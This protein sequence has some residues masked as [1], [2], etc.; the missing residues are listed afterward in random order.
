MTHP[1]N[2]H[3]AALI[4]LGQAVYGP[5]WRLPPAMSGT[6]PAPARR[7]LKPEGARIYAALRAIVDENWPNRDTTSATA[8]FDA[9]GKLQEDCVIEM[10][11]RQVQR[12]ERHVA[13]LPP[14]PI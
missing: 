8:L 13:R 12:A 2:R 3:D 11:D 7:E 10:I 9:L 1:P 5:T 6:M 4:A 14:M